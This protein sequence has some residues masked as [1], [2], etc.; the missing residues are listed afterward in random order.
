MNHD[1]H[2]F[3]HSFM[4]A[5]DEDRPLGNQLVLA[6]RKRLHPRPGNL[7]K[8]MPHLAFYDLSYL[9]DL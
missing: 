5:T 7:H 4:G 1:V 3:V 2:R 9:K 8:I 6:E